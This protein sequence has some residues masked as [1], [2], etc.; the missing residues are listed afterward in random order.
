MIVIDD[1]FQACILHSSIPGTDELHDDGHEELKC[2]CECIRPPKEWT[3]VTKLLADP[4][5]KE[6]KN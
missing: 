1:E 5:F 6:K 4:F 3:T 2:F